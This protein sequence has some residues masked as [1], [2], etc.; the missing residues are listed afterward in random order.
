LNIGRSGKCGRFYRNQARE[1]A[2]VVRINEVMTADVEIASPDD[3]LRTAAKMMAD[4][5]VGV[6]PV[7]ENARLMGMLTDRDIAVRAVAEGVDTERAQVRDIMTTE[8]RY[9]FDD[10]LADDV[11]DKMAEWQLRRL[12]VLNREKRLIGIV[13]VG[14]LA[15]SG[16]PDVAA[17]ALEGISA[18]GGREPQHAEPEAAYAGSKP[19]HRGGQAAASDNSEKGDPQ[20]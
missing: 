7:G 16:E 3:T 12:P 20:D 4:L 17:E 19:K 1:R 2:R 13:S 9:C 10:E 6:L 14:D 8:L 11:A 18:T 5:E 15:I